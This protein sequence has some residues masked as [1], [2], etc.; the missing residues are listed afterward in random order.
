MRTTGDSNLFVLTF[1]IIGVSYTFNRMIESIDDQINFSLDK[2]KV[3]EKL[4]EHNIQ[5]NVGISFK[6]KPHY[7]LE[8]LKELSMSVENKSKALA[9]YIDWDNSSIVIKHSKQSMRVIRKSPDITRD[10]GVPQSPSLVAPEKTLTTAI[11]SENVFKR[12]AAS[13]TY[14]TD[15]AIVDISGL[16]KHPVKANRLLFRRFMA[17]QE[18]LEFSLQLVLRISEVRAGLAPGVDVPPMVIVNCP[19]IIKK[20]PW[21]YA[22]PWNKKRG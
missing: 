11:T 20:L 1:Y 18:T 15:K 10:L 4:K 2:A 14:S 8:E 3:D 7:G 19:F 17:R 6:F 13:G 9:V 5:D 12:D 22:L 16:Q 21:T